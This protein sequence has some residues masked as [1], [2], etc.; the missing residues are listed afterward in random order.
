MWSKSM[1]EILGKKRS[2]ARIPIKPNSIYAVHSGFGKV[3]EERAIRRS[4]NM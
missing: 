1:K 3:Y 4:S 2:K